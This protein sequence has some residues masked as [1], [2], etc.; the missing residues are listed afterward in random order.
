MPLFLGKYYL[1]IDLG[2]LYDYIN[3]LKV[4]KKDSEKFC[5]NLQLILS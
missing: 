5:K 3:Y 2:R 1:S 4:V